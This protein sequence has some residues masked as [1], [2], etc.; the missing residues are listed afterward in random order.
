MRAL[1]LV[2]LCLASSLRAEP[3][4]VMTFNIRY[5]TANDGVNH[6][7]FRREGVLRVL[8]EEAPAI[9][10][11]QEALK[12][13]LDEILAAL[14]GYVRLGVGRDDGRDAGE[15]SPIL[16][17]TSRFEVVSQQTF[18]LSDTPD[19]PGTRTWGNTI[20]R[21]CTLARLKQRADGRTLWVG[22]SHFDHLSGN[23]RLKSAEAV[24]ARLQV[25][26][27]PVLFLGDLNC[28]PDS[29]PLRVL[30]APVGE[31]GAALSDLTAVN[32]GLRSHG[33]FHGWNGGTEGP[34]IDFVLGRGGWTSRDARIRVDPGPPYPSDHYPVWALLEW[35]VSTAA[36][37]P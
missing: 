20:P 13:Q 32:P 9:C 3:V 35:P 4:K 37:A 1:L 15:F 23:S 18:W 12:F 28:G 36:P 14:P 34:H 31:G 33:T 26:P 21:I 27:D 22:N 8:R 16:V 17:A 11:V 5:G 29:E 7:K 6:W 10:G 24:A 25:L 2:L 30:L 19:T